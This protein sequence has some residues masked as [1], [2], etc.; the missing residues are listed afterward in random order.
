MF[1]AYTQIHK[2]C[3][4]FW[5]Y[6]NDPQEIFWAYSYHK[7]K[8][9]LTLQKQSIFDIVGLVQ[10]CSNSSA[11]ALE[12]L[13]SCTKPSIYTLWFHSFCHVSFILELLRTQKFQGS[14]LLLQFL[15]RQWLKGNGISAHIVS[16][17][18]CQYQRCTFQPFWCWYILGDLV[19]Y[20]GW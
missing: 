18:G 1:P 2:F 7:R 14:S 20:Q 5:K 19:Q 17:T 12:L 8:E 16:A 3:K 4:E 15:I 6:I 11:N 13:Q 10:D 9:K